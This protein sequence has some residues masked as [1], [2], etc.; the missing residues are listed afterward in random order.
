MV[1]LASTSFVRLFWRPEL[2]LPQTNFNLSKLD[3]PMSHLQTHSVATGNPAAEGTGYF[4]NISKISI[5]FLF[6]FTGEKCV[7]LVKNVFYV[8]NVVSTT[9]YGE[10]ICTT[11]CCL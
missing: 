2:K 4:S 11:C 3:S 7:K 8:Y 10:K 1:L 6:N 9:Y 5:F